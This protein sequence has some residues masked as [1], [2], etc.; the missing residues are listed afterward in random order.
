MLRTWY[1]TREETRRLRCPIPVEVFGRMHSHSTEHPLKTSQR[2]AG[3]K[4]VRNMS[5]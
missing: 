4:G 2:A 1:L 3:A 5:Y